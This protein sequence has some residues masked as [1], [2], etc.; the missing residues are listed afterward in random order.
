MIREC[1]I[2]FLVGSLLF[3]SL[4]AVLVVAVLWQTA[5]WVYGKLA[6]RS[7]IAHS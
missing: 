1:W 4:P 2:N 3:F 6:R 7:Q 5:E